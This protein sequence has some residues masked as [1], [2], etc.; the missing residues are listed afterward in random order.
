MNRVVPSEQGGQDLHLSGTI[1]SALPHC[2]PT[3]LNIQLLRVS[4]CELT[5]LNTQLLRVSQGLTAGLS[6]GE[7]SLLVKLSTSTQF[8]LASWSSL[9]VLVGFRSQTGWSKYVP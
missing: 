1:L 2:E 8:V 7:F 6:L 9:G 3:I 4:H 5:V